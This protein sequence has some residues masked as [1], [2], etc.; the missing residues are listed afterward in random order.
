[1]AKNKTLTTEMILAKKGLIEQAPAPF[2]SELFDA[3]IIIENNHAQSVTD[4]I[5]R[6]ASGND[7]ETYAYSRLIYENCP[8]FRDKELIKQYEVDD[9]YLL[10]KTVYG[11]NVIEFLM[12]GNHILSAYGATSDTVGNIKKK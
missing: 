9:P 3:D 10:P 12:L 6:I 11:A 2:Y 1:M 4:I 5:R 7:D 8:I